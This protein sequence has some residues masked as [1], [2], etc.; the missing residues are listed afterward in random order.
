VVNTIILKFLVRGGWFSPVVS[1]VIS[2]SVVPVIS[3]SASRFW[4]FRKH[5]GVKQ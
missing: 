1:A 5:S 2:T 4:A 3:F